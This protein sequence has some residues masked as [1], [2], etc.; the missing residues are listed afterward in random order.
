MPPK[1]ALTRDQIT[2]LEQLPNIGPSIAQDFRLLGIAA[3]DD[4]R[5]RDPYVLYDDLCRVTGVRHD[6]C[7]LDTFISAVRFVE[8]EPAKPWWHYTAERKQTLAA[9]ERK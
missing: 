6:P 9:S 7:V 2:R 3:P 5:G 1:K 4:L 8:G